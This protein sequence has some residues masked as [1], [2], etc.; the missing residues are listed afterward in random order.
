MNGSSRRAT[1]ETET[2][3]PSQTSYNSDYIYADTNATNTVNTSSNTD[4][5]H[6]YNQ[7]TATGASFAT[8]NDTCMNTST[9]TDANN[10]HS[11]YTHHHACTH[12]ESAF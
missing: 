9:D 3:K 5:N 10:H 7:A 8:N 1:T 12:K 6:I 11:V 4:L 2:E